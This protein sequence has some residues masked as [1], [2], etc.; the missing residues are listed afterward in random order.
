M[1]FCVY[2]LNCVKS[3]GLAA[4]PWTS[5]TL[6]CPSEI[7]TKSLFLSRFESKPQNQEVP[8]TLLKTEMTILLTFKVKLTFLFSYA[9]YFSF[10]NSLF[11]IIH[12]IKKNK[13]HILIWRNWEKMSM[14]KYVYKR[15]N[16]RAMQTCIS[17]VPQWIVKSNLSASS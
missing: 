16:Q 9:Y 12:K 3:N 7:S 13:Y 5:Y 17:S 4:E 11:L 10:I 14:T 1:N 2:V 15:N 6:D 8:S